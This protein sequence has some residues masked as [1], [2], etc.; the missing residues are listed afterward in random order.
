VSGTPSR[1]SKRLAPTRSTA[2]TWTTP[3]R[4]PT[5]TVGMGVSYETPPVD[6]ESA[7]LV[8]SEPG[9]TTELTVVNYPTLLA[10]TRSLRVGLPRSAT[11]FFTD[12]R[13]RR[14]SAQGAQSPE[15]WIRSVPLL[16]DGD[17][18]SCLDR[19]SCRA[20]SR[21]DECLPSQFQCSTGTVVNPRHRVKVIQRRRCIP[22][23]LRCLSACADCAA[24]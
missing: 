18:M 7:E 9:V 2:S 5:E 16:L 6:A 19:L 4:D 20:L 21:D 1:L 15:A 22:S 11:R 3:G 12:G 24:R 17:D 8:E 10:L 13:L 14:Q 23:L